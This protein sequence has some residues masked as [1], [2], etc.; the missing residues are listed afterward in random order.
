MTRA[1]LIMIAKAIAATRES[2]NLSGQPKRVVKETLNELAVQIATEFSRENPD[3]NV[4][5]FPQACA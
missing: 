5:A 3:F 4:G 2:D 1:E